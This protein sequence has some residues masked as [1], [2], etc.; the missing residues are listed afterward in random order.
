[1][2]LIKFFECKWKKILMIF[3]LI[4]NTITFVMSFYYLHTLSY[5]VFVNV[6][7]LYIVLFFNEDRHL[8]TR[9]IILYSIIGIILSINMIVFVSINENIFIYH[10][11]FLT[12]NVEFLSIQL[13][14]IKLYNNYWNNISRSIDFSNYKILF[15]PKNILFPIDMTSI[16]D[17]NTVV[18]YLYTTYCLKNFSRLYGYWLLWQSVLQD[19]VVIYGKHPLL[20]NI[21]LS[22]YI[23][24]LILLCYPMNY[25]YIRPIQTPLI[26]C[27]HTYVLIKSIGM[28]TVDYIIFMNEPKLLVYIIIDIISNIVGIIS[29]V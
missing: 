19:I 16:N 9:F 25:T 5:F 24:S 12:M 11:I 13:L 14:K 21:S 26:D 15:S 28:I 18:H 17:D 20:L 23:L 22:N 3:L 6:L 7:S 2:N 4:S 8:F 27:P 10:L 1:M 29:V